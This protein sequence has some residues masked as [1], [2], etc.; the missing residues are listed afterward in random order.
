LQ[1]DALSVAE[2]GDD[3][4]RWTTVHGFVRVEGRWQIKEAKGKLP[5]SDAVA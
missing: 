3:H 4:Y 5:F 2:T 1:F